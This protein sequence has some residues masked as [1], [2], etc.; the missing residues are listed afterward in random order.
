MGRR[1]AASGRPDAA[2]VAAALSMAQPVSGLA[3]GRD[4]ET[5]ETLLLLELGLDGGIS[6]RLA[7]DMIDEL[8]TAL[9]CGSEGREHD[10]MA[11]E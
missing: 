4:S 1:L 9:D 6:V 10:A 7:S 8:C 5:D 2:Q 11:T 3:V